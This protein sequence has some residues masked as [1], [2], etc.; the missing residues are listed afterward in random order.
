MGA[1]E[2]LWCQGKATFK[3]L[4]ERFREQQALPSDLVDE[5][6]AR[7]TAKRTLEVLHKANVS[8]FSVRVHGE[9]EY[10]E[11]LRDAAHPVELLYYQ[12]W[13]NLLETPS[14]AVVGTRNPSPEGILR[15]KKLVR[16][17]VDDRWSIISGLA[18]GIDTVAHHTAIDAGGIT[19]GV[20]GTPLSESYPKRNRELQARLAKEFL[21]IS[22]VPVLQYSQ[23]DYRFN[24]G[25]FRERNLTMSALTRATIIIEAGETSGTLIQARAALAQGR[26]LFILDSCFQSPELTWPRRFEERGAIRVRSYDDI[27]RVLGV[28]DQN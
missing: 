12:G 28:A 10:P 22:Q 23:R 17:L 18:K 14:V 2:A 9:I 5:Q 19:I 7:S 27:R 4:A 15:A 21:V 13:W 24:R 20:L 26:K 11:K 25:Y 3:A 1:Y 16:Q 6:T 8:R